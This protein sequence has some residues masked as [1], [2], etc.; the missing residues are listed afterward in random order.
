VEKTSYD[1]LGVAQFASDDEIRGAYRKLAIQFHPDKNPDDATAA[2]T[3][4]QIVAAYES[5]R[6]EESRKKYD[7]KRNA[8]QSKSD[9]TINKTQEKSHFDL[10]DALRSFMGSMRYDTIL[11]DSFEANRN[12]PD[13]GSN[14]RITV[15]LTLREI[16]LGVQK[17]ITYAH[18][19]ICNSCNGTGA[20]DNQSKIITCRQCGGHGIVRIAGQNDKIV[21][22][23]CK[24]TAKEITN[25]CLQCKGT[26]QISGESTLTVR[27]PQGIG[28]GNILTFAGKGNS[29]FRGGTAGDLLVYIDEIADPQFRRQGY[30]L[31]TDATIPVLTAILG[32]RTMALTLD[33]ETVSLRI[34]EGTQP[35][36]L[37]ALKF[38]GLPVYK[39]T[40]RGNLYVRVHVVIPDKLTDQERL[41]YESM[42][43][44][45]T[46]TEKNGNN[47][48]MPGSWKVREKDGSWRI[49]GGD[50]K[51]ND[52]I[53]DHPE[54]ARILECKE[55]KVGIDLSNVNLVHSL[56]IGLWIKIWKKLQVN[57]SEFF[58]VNPNP[59]V[60]NVLADMNM[61]SIFKIVNE[62]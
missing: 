31:E 30:D 10:A 1:I 46:D 27:F 26:G 52:A 14:V 12:L 40:G 3:F 7:D 25:P 50:G 23:L 54:V 4:R 42:T 53:F 24:G 58:I 33:G 15:P 29:G 21:C 55:V 13:S 47:D 49:N 8:S 2:D 38:C 56:A 51:F 43:Y 5:I 61:D 39:G 9:T 41:C 17:T 45:D 22:L 6:D 32:G 35:E 48:T 36:T 16:A 59:D 60:M 34:P 11:R 57:G 62:L 18:T 28:E 20:S 37:F 44:R 19:K